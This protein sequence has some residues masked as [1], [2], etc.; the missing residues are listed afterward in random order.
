[1][2]KPNTKSCSA[3]FT[4]A[5]MCV[6][7]LAACSS[8]PPVDTTKT[9]ANIK[10]LTTTFQAEYDYTWNAALKEMQRY[11]LKIINKDAGSIMTNYLSA[12]EGR[13]ERNEF[14]YYIELKI[15]SLPA[16]NSI[17]Q[18]QVVVTKYI[19]EARGIEGNRPSVSDGV[20]EQVITHRIKRLL[21]IE[22]AKLERARN[23]NTAVH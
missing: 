10:P 11:D 21:E 19:H 12:Y 16:L 23:K 18:T 4:F 15:T 6:L 22:R 9:T 7:F 20:D 1:M 14:R 3:Y 13:Q 17:P 5:F 2:L 8:A